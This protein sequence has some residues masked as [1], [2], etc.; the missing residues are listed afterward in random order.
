MSHGP[1]DMVYVTEFL[2]HDFVRL[3]KS[4]PQVQNALNRIRSK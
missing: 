4:E 3:Q 1:C 2:C